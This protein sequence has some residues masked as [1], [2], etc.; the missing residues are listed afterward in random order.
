MY[1]NIT[2]ALLNEVSRRKTMSN[3]H[4]GEAHYVQKEGKQRQ[5]TNKHRN[6]SDRDGK[7]DA[8]RGCSKSRG[9]KD[10]QCHFCDKFGHLKKDC[11]AW[12]REKGKGKEK[13]S[14]NASEDK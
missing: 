6:D 9:K 14:S 8:S 5:G 12:K 4:H 3:S 2:G 11:Y 7:E 13:G 1:G 10:I